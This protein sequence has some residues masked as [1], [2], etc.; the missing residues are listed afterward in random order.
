[1]SQFLQRLSGFFPALIALALPTLYLP[2][3]ATDAYILP[4]A[5]LVIVGAG[6]GSGLMLLLPTGPSLG[7][8]RWPLAA[9]ALAAALAFVFSVSW[10]L[11]LAGSY[12]R[13]E[14]LPMRLSYLGLFAVPV[15]LLRD[16]AARERVV[17]A[18]VFGTSVACI[19][20]VWQW[21]THVPFR[22]DGNLGNANLLGALIAMA[23]PLAVARGLRGGPYV[24]A[25]SMAIVLLAGGILVTTS[26]SGALGA[27]AGCLAFAVLAAG[28]RVLPMGVFVAAGGV[29]AAGVLAILV[30]PLSSLNGDP[31][32]LRLGLWHDA[33]QMVATRPLTGWG[34]DTTGLAFG[35]FLSRDYAS[36]VTFD[37]IHS[38]PL[39]LTAMLGLL[40]LA[41][42]GWILVVLLL[43]VWR[44]RFGR[45]VAALA[46]AGIGYSVWVVFNF[47]WAPATGAFWLI[48]GTAWSAARSTVS[49]ENPPV[50]G[51]RPAF[52]TWWH[53]GTALVLVAA[54]AWLGVMPILADVWNARGRADLAVQV[55]PWQAQYHWALGE[56]L[57][58]QGKLAPGVDELRRAA[59]LGETEPGF[60]VELGDR[61][62]QLGRRDQGIA[63]YR[64]AL[65]IDPFYNPAKQRLAANGA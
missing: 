7:A 13:Y 42:T 6:L 19:E 22:P 15:W 40:G 8:M 44:Q 30:T 36:L 17:P 28:G 2:V 51:P 60:Y 56:V 38:G 10:P 59:N 48:G 3:G 12:T 11:S 35:Q 50:A 18:F 52:A 57:L 41:T 31:P 33:A 5:S 1:M 29:F 46:A 39:D 32:G 62:I 9:A 61:E 64:R 63:E 26:R 65:V 37:R 47:D 23:L 58:A 34:E 25:W 43:G 55:D 49:D 53:S 14:T 45:D 24:V 54:A 21:E 4:R 16:A 20:A 27:L